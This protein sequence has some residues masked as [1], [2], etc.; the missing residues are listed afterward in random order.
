MLVS[1]FELLVKPIAPAGAGPASLARTV[2]QGYFLTIANTSSVAAPLRLTFR[3]TTPNVDPATTVTIIDSNGT[4]NFGDLAGG[5]INLTIPANDTT[6]FIL[7]PDV[8]IPGV[9][10]AQNLEVRGYVEISA[11]GFGFNTFELLLTPEHRGTFFSGNAPAPGPDIDQL[12]YALPTA[13]GKAQ[14]SVPQRR[15]IGPVLENLPL[16]DASPISENLQE[17]LLEMARQVD[18]LSAAAEEQTPIQSTERAAI[19]TP[20]LSA[21]G[22]GN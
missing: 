10:A 8:R 6:L 1:T 14:Y 18:A 22:N 4:N 17:A 2:V 16:L 20:V 21:V 5:S 19:G 13:L 7:Q 15:L 9:L 3:A 12:V 11:R